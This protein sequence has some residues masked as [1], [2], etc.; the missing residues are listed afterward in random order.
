MTKR[1]I[2]ASAKH[3]QDLLPGQFFLRRD[4]KLCMKLA[5]DATVTVNTVEL[6]SGK[7]TYL[8]PTSPVHLAS[9]FQVQYTTSRSE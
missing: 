4:N 7:T 6:F 2:P 9:D 3:F 1:K 8:F 5:E